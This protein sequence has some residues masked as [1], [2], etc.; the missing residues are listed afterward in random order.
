MSIET[1]RFGQ[2]EIDPAKVWEFAEG[3]PG[4][5]DNHRL[6]LL[7]FE[8]SK[9]VAW[10][11]SLDD[12]DVC[13]PVTDTFRAFPDY[14][15]DVE[16]EVELELKLNVAGHLLVLSV[17][18]IPEDLTQMTCNMAAPILVN[19]VAKIGRQVILPTSNYAVRHPVFEAL[20]AQTD[21]TEGAD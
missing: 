13:L 3:L 12:V 4:L 1:V 18:V 19:T 8:E 2:V 9:P 20:L 11:Q 10:L 21:E 14:E 16:E 5:E 6:V 15:F 17:L 7:E